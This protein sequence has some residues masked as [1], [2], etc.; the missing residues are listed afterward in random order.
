MSKVF[1]P[2]DDQRLPDYYGIKVEYITGKVREYKVASHTFLDALRAIEIKTF[3]NEFI[4]IPLDNIML[5]FD[6]EFTKVID[7][8]TEMAKKKNE[9][10]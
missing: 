3:D 8:K 7:I 4:V 2:K 6:K 10:I 9:E 1:L 5:T